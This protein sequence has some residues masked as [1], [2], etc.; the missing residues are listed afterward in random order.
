ML[1]RHARALGALLGTFVGDAVGM[2]YEGV[3]A[4]SIPER[5]E[6]VEARL[7]RGTYTDDTEMMIL[8]AESLLACPE[9]D[10]IDLGERF[11]AGCDP[12]RGYGSGTRAVLALWRNGVPIDEA[13]GLIFDGQGSA[14][15]GAAMRVAPLAVRYADAPARV[16]SEAE[17]SARVTHTHPIGVDGAIIQASAI[18]AALRGDPILAAAREAARTP[19]LVDKLQRVRELRGEPARPTDV[20]EELGCGS[21]ADRSVPTAI[22]CALVHDNFEAAVSFAV[23][24]GGDTDT[25]A[26][27]TGAIAGARDGAAGIP[28]RW[29]KALEDGPRGRTYVERLAECLS[30]DLRDSQ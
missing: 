5:L 16:R 2:P 29:L 15:N 6:M 14:G 1:D 12:A 26:A 27:M 22:F 30:S 18:A 20:A 3:P 8:V 28:E 13:A 17:R 4:P 7:G 19:E 21:T 24:C 9:L 23:S 10:P 11:L 25:I